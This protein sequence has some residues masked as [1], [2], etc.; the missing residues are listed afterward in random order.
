VAGAGMVHL[1]V[2]RAPQHAA[3][4]GA[5]R[6]ARCAALSGGSARRNIET[7]ARWLLLNCAIPYRRQCP[8]RQARGPRIMMHPPGTGIIRKL[9]SS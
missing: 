8:S 7:S 5:G 6:C 9:V 2:F 1:G 3:A 4:S